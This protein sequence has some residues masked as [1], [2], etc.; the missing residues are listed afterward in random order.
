MCG[1][2]TLKDKES[3]PFSYMFQ[4]AM[5]HLL[6]YLPANHLFHTV[7]LR[8]LCTESIMHHGKTNA[9]RYIQPVQLWIAL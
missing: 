3:K 5:K 7:F 9:S 2:I 6:N 8:C 4:L 1:S